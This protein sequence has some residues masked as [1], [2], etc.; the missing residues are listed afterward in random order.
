MRSRWLPAAAWAL[1]IEA[2]IVW[3]HPPSLPRAWSVPG[4]DKVVHAVLF[5]VMAVLAM[6]A[7]LTRDRAWFVAFVGTVAFGA[8]TEAQQYFIPSRSL[9]LGDILADTA[10]AAMG[11]VLF[12]TLAQRRR[13]F[14]R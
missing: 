3:P 1:V 4:I 11:L 14:S 13:E 7:L 5:G 9:E 6:R 10:G 12:V 8:F 2:L